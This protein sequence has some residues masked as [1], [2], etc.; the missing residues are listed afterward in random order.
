[1]SQTH[2]NVVKNK[3]SVSKEQECIC[4]RVV[5]GYNVVVR[6]VA[7]SGKTTTLARLAELKSDG[8]VII[9]YNRR[10]AEET[11]KKIKR[12]KIATLHS[13]CQEIYGVDCSNDLGLQQIISTDDSQSTKSSDDCN[14]DKYCNGTI[15]DDDS[16]NNNNDS[17]TYDPFTDSYEYSRP[18]TNFSTL[19]I[20][21]A[22]DLTPLMVNVINKLLRDNSQPANLVLLGDELQG[23]YSYQG[24]TPEFLLNPQ[25][26]FI[27]DPELWLFASLS[28]SWRCPP[29][30]CKF[31]SQVFNIQMVPSSLPTPISPTPSSSTHLS[32]TSSTP[33]STTSSTPLS[34]TSSTPLS[35]TSSTPLSTTSS[36]PLSTTPSASTATNVATVKNNGR[37]KY[38]I[39]KPEQVVEYILDYMDRYNIAPSSAC[40]ICSYLRNNYPLIQIT[41]LLSTRG[42]LPLFISVLNQDVHDERLANGKFVVSSIH[43]MKGRERDCVFVY[44]FDASYHRIFTRDNS[45][46]HLRDAKSLF[47]VALTR[48]KK[49]C[50]VFQDYKEK[51]LQILP[52]LDTL[53]E[54]KVMMIDELTEVDETDIRP[55]APLSKQVKNCNINKAIGCLGPNLALSLWSKIRIVEIQPC[56]EPLTIP[57]II[58]TSTPV[59][60]LSDDSDNKIKENDTYEDIS[61]LISLLLPVCLCSWWSHDINPLLNNRGGQLS[62]T[63]REYLKTMKCEGYSMLARCC[64]IFSCSKQGYLAPLQQINDFSW[65]QEADIQHALERMSFLSPVGVQWCKQ[66]DHGYLYGNADLTYQSSIWQLKV[67]NDVSVFDFFEAAALLACTNKDTAYIY[68]IYTNQIVM[69]YF[70]NDND[71]IDYITELERSATKL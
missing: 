42:G 25:R 37:V 46:E 14:F 62:S 12:A 48:A 4:Q 19:V 9:M 47:Y 67:Q 6:A 45:D 60:I 64:Q 21:E 61:S 54:Q 63:F 59:N 11:R 44:G 13:Y 22:Q 30:L 69:V 34:T 56:Q 35:T 39:C 15:N 65:L 55:Y 1:M 16:N 71:R 33:L 50:V 17:S 66:V 2:K 36:T 57:R 3:V 53:V 7:G 27:A 68:N 51:P 8:L 70:D 5:E 24:A 58:E 38:V 52:S 26:F 10:L 31:V 49:H 40:L 32:T 29:Y 41:N 43:A 18:K 20:D 23:I 28:T